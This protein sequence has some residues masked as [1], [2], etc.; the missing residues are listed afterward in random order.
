[1][2]PLAVFAIVDLIGVMRN[3][4]RR[5][6][7][8]GLTNTLL[9]DADALLIARGLRGLPSLDENADE[10]LDEKPVILEMLRMSFQPETRRQLLE[11]AETA[12]V[13]LLLS[14]PNGP[15]LRGF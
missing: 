3:Y 14:H 6:Y 11:A 1:M 12:G 2:Y 5:I 10:K 7:F 15:A 13:D 8:I 4:T 9:S